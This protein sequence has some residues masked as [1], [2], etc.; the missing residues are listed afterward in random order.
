[1][2]WKDSCNDN[3]CSFEVME[4][5]R[6]ATFDIMMKCIMGVEDD[7]QHLGYEILS[8]HNTGLK[9]QILAV[10]SFCVILRYNFLRQALT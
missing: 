6:L 2:K 10:L 8:F 7:C 5:I 3:V 4:D 9:K 1:M